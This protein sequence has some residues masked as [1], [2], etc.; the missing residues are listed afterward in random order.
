MGG[1]GEMRLQCQAN[2]VQYNTC[3]G[4]V[5][6]FHFGSLKLTGCPRA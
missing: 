3:S 2:S 5:F 6:L 4:Y 1:R